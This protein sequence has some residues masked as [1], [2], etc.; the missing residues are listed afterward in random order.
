M[1]QELTSIE[2]SKAENGC[3]VRCSYRTPSKKKSAYDGYDYENKQYTAQHDLMERI[4]QEVGEEVEI[5]PK[6][7][8][9]YVTKI[10]KK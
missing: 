3:I 4:L 6:R 8:V 9:G 2:I 1:A 7:N 5:K 10:S